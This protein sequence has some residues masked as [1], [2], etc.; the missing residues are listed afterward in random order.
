MTTVAVVAR[1]TV[2]EA[3]RRR[4]LVALAGI[5]LAMVDLSAWGF[6]RFSRGAGALP[7]GD[8]RASTAAALIAFMFMFSFVISLSAVVISAPAVSGEI[9]SGV[10]QSVLVRPVRRFEVLLGRWAGMAG[11]VAA[12]AVAAGALEVLVVWAVSG[13]APPD[14]AAAIAYLVFEG[15]LVL[16]LTLALSTFLAPMTAGAVAV[17]LFGAAWLAGVV[18]TI[19]SNLGIGSLQTAGRIA[20]VVLPTDGLWHA[21]IWYLE[22]VSVMDRVLGHGGGRNVDP[23]TAT[24]APPVAYVVWAVAWVLLIFALA[25]RRF[26]RIEP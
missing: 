17:A 4:L 25:V 11:V 2:K 18:G 21:A 15:L 3:S 1:A 22:P 8:A 14:P 7:S 23:F 10:A 13:Y 6:S 24:G 26:S 20:K 16:T 12:Y 19:G 5:S 9:E